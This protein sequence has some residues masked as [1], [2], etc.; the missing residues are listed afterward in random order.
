MLDLQ[1]V[2]PVTIRHD[3]LSLGIQS[4]EP[5]PNYRAPQN[6][7]SPAL[8]DAALAFPS[9]LAATANSKL[10]VGGARLTEAVEA[11][12]DWLEEMDWQP[13]KPRACGEPSTYLR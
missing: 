10:Q 12:L 11:P 1:D 9:A 13:S 6:G 7:D 4:T 2:D 5:T 3:A 8:R